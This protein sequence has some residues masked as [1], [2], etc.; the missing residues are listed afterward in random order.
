MKRF[1]LSAVMMLAGFSGWSQ[2][3]PTKEFID[4][5]DIKAQ[6]MV[7][8]D[9]WWDPATMTPQCEYPKGS[10]KHA[11]FLGSIWIGG[12]DPQGQ[13]H[14]SAQTYRQNGNDYWPGPLDN[15]GTIDYAN[16]QKWA[17]IWKVNRTTV[18]SFRALSSHTT[19]NTP[20]SI[21]T[22]PGKGS[23]NAKGNNNVALQINGDMAPFVDVNNDGIYNPLDGDYPAIKGDQMLWW[24]FNDN[25]PTHDAN[26]GA[27][28][29]KFEVRTSAYAY[30]TPGM[31]SR[32]V[33]YEFAVQNKSGMKYDSL[34]MGL[35]S[36]A[37]L[38][39]AFDDYIG[40]DSAHRMGISYN[41]NSVDGSGQPNSY[42]T[43]IPISGVSLVEL[44]GDNYPNLVPAGSFMYYNNGNSP[45]GNPNTGDEFVFSGRECGDEH[46][47]HGHERDGQQRPPVPAER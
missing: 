35:F 46:R 23:T 6:H 45:T 17:K 3:F 14:V 18:D 13:L 27:Q 26:P 36:D 7:H 43:S 47:G 40:F 4:I 37:D 41:G 32:T 42:G 39:Y 5:N 11:S 22:W 38:G 44:P 9:M 21:L 24:I 31:L 19:A 1:Y 10:G 2:A 12:F 29:L 15:N 20:A 34:V 33:Y 16:S 30:K 28:S 8:G 25:G